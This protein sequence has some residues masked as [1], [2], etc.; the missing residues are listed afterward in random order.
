MSLSFSKLF[1]RKRSNVSSLVRGRFNSKFPNAQHVLWHQIDALIWQV[2]FTFKRKKYL[3][4]FNSEGKW[5]E[6]VSPVPLD[7]IPETVQLTFQEKYSKEGLLQICH[8]QTPD[9]NLYEMEWHNG[10]SALK[11]L[12]DNSGKTVGRIRS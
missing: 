11:L 12:Y 9:S 8:V 10:I 5:L 4:L 1:R 2:N 6:T 3:A 7:K